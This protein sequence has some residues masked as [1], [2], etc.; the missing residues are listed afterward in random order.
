MTLKPRSVGIGLLVVMAMTSA[1]AVDLPALREGLWA[2]RI[3]STYLP[4][5]NRTLDQS[6]LCRNHAYDSYVRQR[7]QEAQ[8]R[9]SILQE[10]FTASRWSQEARCVIGE[11]TVHTVFTEIF[12]VDEVHAQSHTTY[13]PPLANVTGFTTIMESH[14][15]GACPPG[16]QPGDRTTA[17]GTVQHL[18]PR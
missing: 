15:V 11:R 1:G 7:D 10:H 18:W 4:A 16:I 14:Y 5:N 8:S 6:T 17:D 12:A 9:C 2:V 3:E 13:T